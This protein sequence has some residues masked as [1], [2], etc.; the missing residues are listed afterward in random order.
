M[1]GAEIVE[2][3]AGTELADAMQHLAGMLRVL[4]HQRF[5]EL[6]LE[7]AAREA[8]TGDDGA[9]I[10]DQVLPQQLA[11]RDIDAGKDRVAAARAMLPEAELAGGALEHEQA[12]VDDEADL[13]RNVDE[14]DRRHPPHLGMVPA[15]QRLEAGD[16]TVL[17]PHD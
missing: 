7:A 13:L 9:Q 15:R 1:P 5:G 3:E 17:Q 11:R 10:M 16:R 14:I 8:R 12:K 4:H 6:E 2:R